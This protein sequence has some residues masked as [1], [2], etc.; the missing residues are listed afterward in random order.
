M[1]YIM[2]FFF[3]SKGNINAKYHNRIVLPALGFAEVLPSFLGRRGEGEVDVPAHL[4]VVLVLVDQLWY[5]LGGES[6]EE[7]LKQEFVRAHIS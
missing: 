3:R 4:P 5:E 7:T 2:H 1:N 6:D